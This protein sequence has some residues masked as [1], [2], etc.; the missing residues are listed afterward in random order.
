[1][2]TRIVAQ[3]EHD[4]GQLAAG[5]VLQLLELGLKPGI[6]LLAEA[7]DAQIG[8]VAA[9]E[10]ATDRLD[11]DDRAGQGHVER[12]LV[13]AL[14]GELDLRVDGP[15]HLVDCLGEREARDRLAV[16]LDDEIAGL[17]TGARR[18]RV[19]DRRYDL[20]EAVLHSDFDAETTEFA[21]GLH[22]HLVEALGV[23]IARV[24]VEGGEHA[25]YGIFHQLLIGDLLHIVGADF[26]EHVAKQAQLLI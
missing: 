21:A 16:E 11:L 19:V 23:E 24:R 13:A 3:V 15:A 25:I 22:L 5:L 7:G 8:N 17:N 9:F 10:V 2:S 20:D 14:D 4:A 26:F 6:S 18:W 1:E 12:L